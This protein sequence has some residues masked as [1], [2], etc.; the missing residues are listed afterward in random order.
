[1]AKGD[2]TWPQPAEGLAGDIRE[3]EES[4]WNGSRGASRLGRG[5]WEGG[6]GGGVVEGAVEFV[7]EAVVDGFEGHGGGPFWV[8]EGG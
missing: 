3:Q 4:D 7:Q 8:S 5:A 6:G 1:V 2:A